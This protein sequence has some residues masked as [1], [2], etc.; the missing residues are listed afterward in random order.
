MKAGTAL[1]QIDDVV[2]SRRRDRQA[3][4]FWSQIAVELGSAAALGLWLIWHP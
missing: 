4:W 1:N 3:E 2:Q